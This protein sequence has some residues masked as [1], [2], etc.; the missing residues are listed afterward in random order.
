[1][2]SLIWLYW[3]KYFFD[4]SQ[5]MQVIVSNKRSVGFSNIEILDDVVKT[6]LKTW[7]ITGDFKDQSAWREFIKPS[8]LFNPL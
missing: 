5:C 4:K 3:R 6:N 8:M 1:M 2:A 7:K